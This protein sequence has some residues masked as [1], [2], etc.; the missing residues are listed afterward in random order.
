ME[1]KSLLFIEIPPFV[2]ADG[3]LA[4]RN[5]MIAQIDRHLVAAAV[6]HDVPV[7]ALANARMIARQAPDE[8]LADMLAHTD[9]DTI[10]RGGAE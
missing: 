1:R 2:P 7:S 10:V 6:R 3:K 5:R 8:V 9:F 4:A